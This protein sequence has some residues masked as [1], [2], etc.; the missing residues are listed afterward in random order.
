MK[1]LLCGPQLLME[2]QSC[3]Q[4]CSCSQ[5]DKPLG[6]NLA[7]S[8]KVLIQRTKIKLTIR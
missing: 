6:F 2:L 3:V 5:K 1:D 7:I 4:L 8:K